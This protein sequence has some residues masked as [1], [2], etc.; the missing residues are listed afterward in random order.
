[1]AWLGHR[2]QLYIERNSGD[3]H[4]LETCKDNLNKVRNFKTQD[5]WDTSARSY[6]S[7]HLVTVFRAR[8]P[9]CIVYK[10]MEFRAFLH[11]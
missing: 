8:K 5:F 7:L 11:F 10:V 1:M 4:H 3:I 9:V 2:T 6:H